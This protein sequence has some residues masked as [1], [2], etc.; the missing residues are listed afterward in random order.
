MKKYTKKML[1]VISFIMIPLTPSYLFALNSTN[2]A[3]LTITE[4]SSDFFRVDVG[5]PYILGENNTKSLARNIAMKENNIKISKLAGTTIR[6]L[7]GIENDKSTQE[8][9]AQLT[10]AVLNASIINERYFVAGQNMGVYLTAKVEVDKKTILEKL[11]KINE[12]ATLKQKFNLAVE[13]NNLLFDTLEQLDTKLQ[14]SAHAH[15]E[16]LLVAKQKLLNDIY[17]NNTS[18]EDDA[19]KQ[20]AIENAK[21]VIQEQT[22]NDIINIESM[23][24]TLSKIMPTLIANEAIYTTNKVDNSVNIEINIAFEPSTAPIPQKFRGEEDA[25]GLKNLQLKGFEI[26][27]RPTIKLT[28]QD[29]EKGTKGVESQQTIYIVKK[30]KSKVS[31]RSKTLVEDLNKLQVK[32]EVMIGEHSTAL[33]L[34]KH[35]I[36]SLSFQF[37]G[38]EQVKLKNIPKDIVNSYPLKTRVV[39]YTQE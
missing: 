12:D 32:I 19:N 26:L 36:D 14:L 34:T 22:S 7:E 9:I 10:S 29:I 23:K 6:V 17:T 25:Y 30:R 33:N 3:S 15:S 37:K 27:T 2:T 13:E 24:Y 11:K 38:N 18:Y 16:E 4:D 35:N 39:F 31:P 28:A 20:L 5:I 8:R 21:K 1:L